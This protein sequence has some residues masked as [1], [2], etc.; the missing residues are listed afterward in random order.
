MTAQTTA[1]HRTR[2]MRMQSARCGAYPSLL[3][4]AAS[5]VQNSWGIMI[6]VRKICENI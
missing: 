2:N 1:M 5:R 4:F 3:I 6:I